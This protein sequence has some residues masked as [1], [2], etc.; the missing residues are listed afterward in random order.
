MIGDKE[1]GRVLVAIG[2]EGSLTSGYNRH[3]VQAVGVR[4]V[5][6]NSWNSVVTEETKEGDCRRHLKTKV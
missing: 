1:R 6:R 5:V 4:P 3:L 2:L